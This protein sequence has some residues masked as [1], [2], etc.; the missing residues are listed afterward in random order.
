MEEAVISELTS[1]AV[2]DLM[3][4]AMDSDEDGQVRTHQAITEIVTDFGRK[5]FKEGEK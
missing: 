4:V 2:A 5:M 3:R 1:K